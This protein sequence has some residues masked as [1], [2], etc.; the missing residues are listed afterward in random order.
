MTQCH[1][2]LG[3]KLINDRKITEERDLGQNANKED[4]KR[5]IK[6]SL[7]C[8]PG[9]SKKWFFKSKY[10]NA[11][12]ISFLWK[13]KTFKKSKTKMHIVEV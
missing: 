3:G 11:I 4:Q 6:N 12:F 2:I 1:A 9:F 7:N 13:F 5:G 10:K 8:Y